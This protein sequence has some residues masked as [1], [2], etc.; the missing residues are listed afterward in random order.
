MQLTTGLRTYLANGYF[1][2]RSFE[3]EG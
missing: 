2:I 3:R 1:H